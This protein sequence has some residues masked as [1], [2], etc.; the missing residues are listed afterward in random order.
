[1]QAQYGHRAIIKEALE[2]VLRMQKRAARIILKAQ[3]I[4]RTVTMFKTISAQ[5]SSSKCKN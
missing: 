4:T 3:R 1:M 5:R 2:R